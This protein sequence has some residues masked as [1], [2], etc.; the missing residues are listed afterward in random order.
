MVCP[1]NK[2]LMLYTPQCPMLLERGQPAM[3][4]LIMTRAGERPKRAES[5]TISK[6]KFEYFRLNLIT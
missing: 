3:M 1:V 5:K 6:P 2:W 4:Y